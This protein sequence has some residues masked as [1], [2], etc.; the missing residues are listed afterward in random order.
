MF[1][2]VRA[3][4]LGAAVCPVGPLL[5]VLNEELLAV[6]TG[7]KYQMRLRFFSFRVLSMCCL[8]IAKSVQ[9]LV[10]KKETLYV[11]VGVSVKVV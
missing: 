1:L 9:R 3:V 4:V 6:P 2:S 5:M 8:E 10:L 7:T 11:L